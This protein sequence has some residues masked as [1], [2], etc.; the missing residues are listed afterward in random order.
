[1]TSD[2]PKIFLA[3]SALICGLL[4]FHPVNSKAQSSYNDLYLVGAIQAARIEIRT[5]EKTV[6]HLPEQIGLGEDDVCAAR[7]VPQS[8]DWR[9]SSTILDPPRR[10]LYFLA[11]TTK[12]GDPLSNDDPGPFAIWILD[13]ANMTLLNR[14][15]VSD[16]KSL[17]VSADRLQ[18][19]MVLSHDG[20]RLFVG[21]WPTLIVDVFD[22]VAFR[23]TTRIENKGGRPLDTS[24]S[25]GSYFLSG[26][27][28]I[29]GGGMSAGMRTRLEGGR[30]EQEFVDSR[31]QLPAEALKQL[32]EFLKT[33]ANG[34]KFL[35]ATAK[36]SRNGKTLVE[37]TNAGATRMAF[38]TVE[39]ETGEPSRPVVINY[40]ARPELLQSGD[41]VAVFQGKFTKK[42]DNEVRFERTGH[43][44][45]Y[46]AKTAN[47]LHE[48]TKPELAGE[49]TVLCVGQ[50]SSLAAYAHGNE[51]LSVDLNTG[52]T[53]R[54]ATVT[55][56][57]Q[58][59]YSGA[60][61]FE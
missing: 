22:T 5:G 40:F 39:M 2:A 45:I 38:W 47:L 30:F 21:Y 44:A 36:S 9:A 17:G 51:V 34:K 54:L 56:L 61:G 7:N 20:R 59:G 48:F 25:P 28:F 55:D 31:T 46:D 26:E 4:V 49:G 3:S 16:A 1:M 41:Q 32:S 42:N 60:C 10:R 43:F 19:S 37:V 27:K 8:C 58:P 14:L 24:F 52:S 15:N 18:Y 57:P 11:P 12:P 13:S 29:I 33:D 35:P 53:K 50:G 23:K 6:W